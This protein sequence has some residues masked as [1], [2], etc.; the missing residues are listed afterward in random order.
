VSLTF[1]RSTMIDLDSLDRDRR[2]VIFL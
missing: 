2:E 1:A